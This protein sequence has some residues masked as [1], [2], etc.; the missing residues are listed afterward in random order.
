MER[1][2]EFDQMIIAEMPRLQKFAYARCRDAALADDLVQETVMRALKSHHLF[3][4]GSNLRAWLNTILH[5]CFCSHMRQKSWRGEVGDPDGVIANERPQSENQIW[6][7]ELAEVQARIRVL[8]KQLRDIVRLI[9]EGEDYESVAKRLGVPLGTVKSGC[10][11]ARA[12]LEG[13]GAIPQP[14]VPPPPAPDERVRDLF[15]QGLSF[16]E[17]AKKT[18]LSSAEVASAASRLRLRRRRPA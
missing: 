9:A 18:G 4:V 16:S 5:N 13:D 7:L 12:F 2:K 14:E 17:I 8:P 15:D 11:R 3:Q 6:A 1:T 10:S